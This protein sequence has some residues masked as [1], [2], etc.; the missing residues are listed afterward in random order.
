[1]LA[2]HEPTLDPR[3]NWEANLAS[4]EYEVTVMGLKDMPRITADKE[5]KG[6]Y[7]ILRFDRTETH[8]KGMFLKFLIKA[9]IPKWLS[10]FAG[11]IL[12]PFFPLLIIL[13]YI[14]RILMP[15]NSLVTI[16]IVRIMLGLVTDRIKEAGESEKSTPYQKF[17]WLLKY[18]FLPVSVIFWR[19]LHGMAIKPDLVH[20]NDLDTLLIG[21][22]AKKIFNNKLVYDCHEF[23]PYSDVEAT[24]YQKMLSSKLE[25]WLIRYAD[26]IITVNP[27][28]ASEMEKSYKVKIQS[29][30]NCEPWVEQKHS[31]LI[32][33]I[34]KL[35]NGR[36]KFLFQGNFAPMRGIEELINAWEY[37]DGT[38][39][40]LFL[41]GPNNIHKKICIEAVKKTGLLGKGIFFP[42]AVSEEDL[43]SAA[44]QAEIGIIPYKPVCVNYKYACPNK[45]SQYMQAGLTIM[46]NN[47]PYVTSIIDKYSCGLTYDSKDEDSMV[48]AFNYAIDNPD[49]R[50]KCR[51]NSIRFSREEYNWQVQSA[52]L[53][54]I[55]KNSLASRVDT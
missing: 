14:A 28:L 19:E 41:R 34:E 23:W 18:H 22:M 21:V 40:A 10:A 4:E 50:N 9:F 33:E 37:I 12:L 25:K 47:L 27:M 46:T 2:A 44:M 39:A 8:G 1:M 6:N 16:K 45:L 15:K 3:V 13:E 20:C 11:F 43:V 51:E 54:D 24:W 26:H 53:T 42:D 7:T 36:V 5:L 32:N 35:A 31:N 17:K 30:P 55:Y 38:K 52:V 29:L 49:F 48:K